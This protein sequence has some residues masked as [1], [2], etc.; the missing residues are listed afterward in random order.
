MRPDSATVKHLASIPGPAQLSIACIR[1]WGDDE[2]RLR[3]ELCGLI[4][5]C[6]Y[7]NSK[8]YTGKVEIILHSLH[9]SNKVASYFNK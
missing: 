5:T 1:L 7:R 2:T 9:S 3:N 6:Y 8:R 4:S